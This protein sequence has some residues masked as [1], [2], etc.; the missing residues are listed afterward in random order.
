MPNVMNEQC[1]EEGALTIG[2]LGHPIVWIMMRWFCSA[3]VSLKISHIIIFLVLLVQ[4]E[5]GGTHKNPQMQ[6][7]SEVSC[8][9][10]TSTHSQTDGQGCQPLSTSFC[11]QDGNNSGCICSHA[12][13]IVCSCSGDC[14][15]CH[16]LLIACSCFC[17]C[18]CSHAPLIV[19][20][21]SDGCM[22]SHALL[23]ACSC[24]AGCRLCHCL[25]QGKCPHPASFVPAKVGPRARARSF[26]KTGRKEC[27]FLDCG[28]WQCW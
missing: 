19:C 18:T 28:R 4:R 9:A 11:S 25:H 26:S 21:C 20:S 13:L 22:C 7:L 10:C 12:L 23:I 24:S 27:L 16:A 5:F 14:I 17:D 3:W 1:T 8:Y 2:S 15:S 6:D